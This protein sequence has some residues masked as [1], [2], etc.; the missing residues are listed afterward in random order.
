[1]ITIT[2]FKVIISVVAK[3]DHK[4]E[5]LNNPSKYF[6]ITFLMSDIAI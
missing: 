6:L 5:F 4:N 3:S 1:M 2:T